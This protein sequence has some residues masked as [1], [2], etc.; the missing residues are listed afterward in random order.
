MTQGERDAFVNLWEIRPKA[1]EDKRKVTLELEVF[2]LAFFLLQI[3]A[4]EVEELT[5][6]HNNYL[7][8]NV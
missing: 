5:Q 3:T 4:R 2:E 7:G 6:G 1:L 8:M